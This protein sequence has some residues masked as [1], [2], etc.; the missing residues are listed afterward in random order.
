MGT[1]KNGTFD[2]MPDLHQWAI[3]AVFNKDKYDFT[4]NE[5]ELISTL[6]GSFIAGWFRLFKCEVRTY[7]LQPIE[8][9][10]LWDGKNPFGEFKKNE[11]ADERIAVITRATIKLNK[12]KYFWANVAPVAVKMC[13][14]KGFIRSYGVGEIPWI[15]QATFSVWESKEDMKAFAY[16]MRE[17]ADVIKKTRKQQWYS[18]DMFVRFKI[19]N[20]FATEK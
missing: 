16:G 14:A 2:K 6:Y 1:G 20:E 17:H 15:K 5:K 4:Q 13:T 18:E 11:G 9:H 19:I 10:G 3:L 8:G 7:L 12:L